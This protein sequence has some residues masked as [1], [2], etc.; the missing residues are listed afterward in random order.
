MN[1]LIIN[2]ALGTLFGGGESFDLNAARYL[3]RR[4][5]EVTLVTGKPLWREAK[6]HFEDM[7]VVYVPCPELRRHAY[8]AE[9]IHTKLSA[10]FYH[11]DNALFEHSVLR[12]LDRQNA[13]R[14]D[15]AQCCSLFGLPSKL[16]GKMRLPTVSWLP[17]PPSGMVRKRIVPL[18]K[19]PCFALFARGTT[20]WSL[21]QMGLVRD[22][23]FS[24]IEPGVELMRIESVAGDCAR[25]RAQLGLTDNDLLGVTTA[26][27]VRIKNHRFLFQGIAHAKQNG[28]IW[29]WLIVGDGPLADELRRQADEL[30]ISS[31]VHFVGYQSSDEVHRWLGAADV[32]GLTSTYES[33]SIATLE[34][35]AHG[36]PVMATEVGYL[37]HLVRDSGAGLV[38]SPDRPDEL[39]DALVVMVSPDVRR[40]YGQR[41]RQFVSRFDWPL[42]AGK[43]ERLYMQVIDGRLR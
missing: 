6:N 11:L 8:A 12:W 32:F 31:Q 43:L 20:E 13:H 41:G 34:A 36:L 27:L 21:H 22:Q 17:G 2:R 10:A 42:I 15:V 35:M 5:H 29:H 37:Q 1:I 25:M 38:V 30:G 23:D 7:R 33:F 9:R 28:V 24:I 18:V 16:I 26:R 40:E 39:A 19:N 3:M 4:G 14:F